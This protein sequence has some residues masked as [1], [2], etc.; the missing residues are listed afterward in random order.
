[1]SFYYAMGIGSK[2]FTTMGDSDYAAKCT[3]TQSA[4]KAT[5]D[6]HWTGTFMTESSNRQ[7]DTAVIHAFSSFG[8]YDITDE[9]VAKTI[10]VLALTFCGEYALN[11]DDNAAGIPGMLFGRYPGDSYAGGNPWQL[12]TAVVATTF[13]QGASAL[14]SSNGFQKTA[15]KNAWAELLN[16]STEATTEDFI[17][18]SLSA[19][20]AVMNRLYTHVKADGGHIAEQI[21]RSSGTQTSAKDLTWSYANILN[22]MKTRTAAVN[23]L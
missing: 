8:A 9:K 14:V 19:G 13:Y 20:D 10:K 16:L 12:L 4:V 2:F 21:G 11:Q 22:A 15:D 7:R 23:D 17:K 3:A 1:M 18:G 6:S 5:L